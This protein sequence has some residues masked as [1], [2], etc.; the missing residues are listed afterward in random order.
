MKLADP[1]TVQSPCPPPADAH[2]QAAAEKGLQEGRLAHSAGAHH[3]AQENIPLRLPL[4]LI[5]PLLTSDCGQTARVSGTEG[6][7]REGLGSG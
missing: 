7:A 6:A 4:L 5:Q 2:P 1:D 3:L